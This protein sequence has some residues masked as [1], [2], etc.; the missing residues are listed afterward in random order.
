MPQ[1]KHGFAMGYS[2]KENSFFTVG[3]SRLQN[4][5]FLDE[6]TSYSLQRNKWST[7]TPFS[8]KVYDSSVCVLKEKWLYNLGGAGCKWGV[9]RLELD[10]QA[11]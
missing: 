6:V 11:K 2:R 9:S 3:G 4:E 5:S 1:R 8:F 7:M 10:Q